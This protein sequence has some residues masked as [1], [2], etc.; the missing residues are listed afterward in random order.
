MFGVIGMAERILRYVSIVSL[1]VLAGIVSVQYIVPIG[2]R[3]AARY[4]QPA[5]VGEVKAFVNKVTNVR[6]ENESLSYEPDPKPAFF[7][8]RGLEDYTCYRKTLTTSE[9][10]FD[11]SVCLRQTR[12]AQHIL[13][14]LKTEWLQPWGADPLVTWA[15]NQG[16]LQ[17][18]FYDF[19]S[20]RLL[21]DYTRELTDV[22]K[23]YVR[24]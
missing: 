7:E 8:W 13:I 11:V 9:R 12:V 17:G 16:E 22:E 6:Y 3:V 20:G 4:H 19:G 1:V 18:R 10:I 14:D 23:E 21:L 2:E 15:K 24:N 5:F